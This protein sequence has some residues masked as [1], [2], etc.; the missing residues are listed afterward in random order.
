MLPIVSDDRKLVHYELPAEGM[1]LHKMYSITYNIRIGNKVPAGTDLSIDTFVMGTRT[2][3]TLKVVDA[4][5]AG[6][7]RPKKSD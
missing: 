1:D 7:K 4:L 3:L 5:G 2:T 6:S